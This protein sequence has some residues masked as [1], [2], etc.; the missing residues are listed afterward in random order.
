VFIRPLLHP[1]KTITT[2]KNIKKLMLLVS[3]KR[4]ESAALG[5]SQEAA[6]H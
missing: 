6:G 4:N 3:I 1:E 5:S 2:K